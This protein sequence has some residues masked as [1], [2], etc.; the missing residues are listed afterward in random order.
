MP[1]NRLTVI[2]A[3]VIL[4]V[5]LLF[6]AVLL[7]SSQG[8]RKS[9]MLVEDFGAQLQQ[10]PLLGA[11]ATSTMQEKYE[12]YVTPELLEEWLNNVQLAPGRLTSSPYP[13]RIEIEDVVPQGAGYLITG[14][15]VLETSE[16]EA[17]RQKVLIQVVPVDE[18]YRIAVFQQET[19]R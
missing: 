5:A 15:I 16:G 13:A 11:D 7:T 2:A 1:K 10:V 8:E 18:Q 19:Q 6:I 3:L 4:A 9:R 14:V 12:R 17:G